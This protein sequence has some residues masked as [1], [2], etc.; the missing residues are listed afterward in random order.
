MA[1]WVAMSPRVEKELQDPFGGFSHFVTRRKPEGGL[2]VLVLIDSLN[3]PAVG[4]RLK[5]V[6]GNLGRGGKSREDL[7]AGGAGP[8]GGEAR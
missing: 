6:R 3:K 2:E 7:E 5:R 8:G 4:G 1:G